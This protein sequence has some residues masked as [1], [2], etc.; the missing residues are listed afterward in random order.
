MEQAHLVL[1]GERE[2][3]DTNMGKSSDLEIQSALNGMLLR[4]DLH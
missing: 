2:W 1:A 4:A 3:W